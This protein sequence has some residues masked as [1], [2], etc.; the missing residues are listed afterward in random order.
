MSCSLTRHSTTEKF[1]AYW[2]DN[3]QRQY[4]EIWDDE[5]IEIDESEMANILN[6]ISMRIADRRYSK[7]GRTLQTL[8]RSRTKQLGWQSVEV[9]P[10]LEDGNSI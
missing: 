7:E 8:E 5:N 10:Q 6:A 9:H 1:Y 2:P 3:I 4:I